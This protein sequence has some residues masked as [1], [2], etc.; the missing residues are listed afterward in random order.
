[1]S[2]NNIKHYFNPNE[3]PTNEW[4]RLHLERNYDLIIFGDALAKSVT[5]PNCAWKIFNFTL[6]EQT[7]AMD[8]M[9]LQQT[10]SILKE[11]GTA[12]FIL[13]TYQCCLGWKAKKDLRPYYWLFWPYYI[14]RNPLHLFYIRVAKRLPLLM[15]RP[16]D[17]YC[18]I[19]RFTEEKILEREMKRERG[20]L[21]KLTSEKRKAGIVKTATLIKEIIDFCVERNIKPVFTFAPYSLA[22]DEEILIKE[23]WNGYPEYMIDFSKLTY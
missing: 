3:Y 8:F 15:L 10:F 19:R 17:M 2:M 22:T 18:M 1:M 16:Y 21:A 20:E 14:A 7:L 4:Y 5:P 12:L 13:N 9:V 6:K 11:G 23:I